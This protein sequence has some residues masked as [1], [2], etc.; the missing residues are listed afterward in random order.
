[1]IGSHLG[2]SDLLDNVLGRVGRGVV[3]E[4]GPCEQ[5]KQRPRGVLDPVVNDKVSDQLLSPVPAVDLKVVAEAALHLHGSRV[6]FQHGRVKK[7]GE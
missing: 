5:T 6:V 4:L 7:S 3:V 1:M 2:D